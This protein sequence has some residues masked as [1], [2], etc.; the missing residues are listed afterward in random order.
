MNISVFS[1]NDLLTTNRM[2]STVCCA[3]GKIYCISGSSTTSSSSFDNKCYVYDIETDKWGEIANCPLRI[4]YG[5]AEYYNGEIYVIAIATNYP[6]S[7]SA[8][9]GKNHLLKYNIAKDKWY[10]LNMLPYDGTYTNN[11]SSILSEQYIYF[12][13]STTFCRYNIAEDKWDLLATPLATISGAYMFRYKNNIYT[14]GSYV[15]TKTMYVYSIITNTWS[16]ITL[17]D[18]IYSTTGLIIDNILYFISCKVGSN[19]T[20]CGAALYSLDLNTHVITSL[21]DLAN[22][23]G[24]ANHNAISNSCNRFGNSLWTICQTTNASAEIFPVCISFENYLINAVQTIETNSTTNILDINSIKSIIVNS[25]QEPNTKIRYALS[26][27][28]RNTYKIF[29]GTTWENIDK[30]NIIDLGMTK[31]EV[32]NLTSA[33]FLLLNNTPG[34]TLDVIAGLISYDVAFS[35]R[36][37]NIKASIQ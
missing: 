10:F 19:R 36:L 5:S 11:G 14:I 21:G 32:N 35:P 30:T 16:S 31:Q 9:A 1:K 33:D 8:S 15:G 23:F 25:V 26:F 13:S 3:E 17:T 2:Y 27:D 24:G 37:I 20:T 7:A 4:N 29:N 34:F 12:L 28:R 22:G 18:T 6:I